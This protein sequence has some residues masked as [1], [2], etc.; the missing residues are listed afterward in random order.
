[1]RWNSGGTY[2]AIEGDVPL[3]VLAPRF[4]HAVVK[5]QGERWLTK[6]CA[7]DAANRLTIAARLLVEALIEGKIPESEFVTA[8]Q[9]LDAGDRNADRAL[10]SSLRCGSE[11]DASVLF[12]NVDALYNLLDH[13]TEP[14][15]GD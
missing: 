1:M 4:D 15:D 10:L 2:P 14:G 3:R 9:A 12:G 6:F 11:A 8:Q 7:L 5:E 13:A